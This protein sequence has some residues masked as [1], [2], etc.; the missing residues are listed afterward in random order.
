[1]SAVFDLRGQVSADVSPFSKAMDST[2]V[3]AS[4][5]FS[6]MASA[7]AMHIGNGVIRHF[8]RA[9][10]A[11]NL[12]G[13]KLAD[14][15]AIA[16]YNLKSLRTSILGIENVYGRASDVANTMYEVISSG[17]RGSEKDLMHYVQTAKHAAVSIKADLYDTASAMTN[18]TNAYGTGVAG[19]KNIADMLFVTVR[20]GKA[21]GNEL[22]RTLGLVTNTAAEAGVSLAEMS[23]AI[24][25]LSRTQSA[26]Q[27]MIGLNQL[28]NAIIKP[29]IEA[30]NEAR[31]WGIELSATALKTK[32]LSGV[33]K[34]LHEKTG[35]NVRALNAMLGNIRAMRAGVS[36]TGKQFENFMD[37]LRM[38][39]TEIGSGVAF[40]AFTKQTQTAAQAI[41]NLS[42]Q[43]D[44]TYIMI[45]SDLE[46]ITKRLANTTESWLKTIAADDFGATVGRWSMYI[47]AAA[48]GLKGIKS[49]TDMFAS[50]VK[51]L[52]D[53]LERSAGHNDALGKA[54]HTTAKGMRDV[55]VHANKALAVIQAM[56]SAMEHAAR[57]A[58]LMNSSF[59]TMKAGI[60]TPIPLTPEQ[61]EAAKRHLIAQTLKP[62][63]LK[64]EAIA[65]L[66][67][68]GVNV[69]DYT[70]DIEN[71][72]ASRDALIRK[73]D[74][75]SATSTAF[76]HSAI[77]P[78]DKSALNSRIKAMRDA[79][80]AE[81]DA[82]RAKAYKEVSVKGKYNTQFV[83]SGIGFPTPVHTPVT[84]YK[85]ASGRFVS[86]EAVTAQSAALTALS[87]RLNRLDA[88]L[89]KRG[90]LESAA[91]KRYA[92]LLKKSEDLSIAAM[93]A[94]KSIAELSD[95][96]TKYSTAQ[97]ESDALVDAESSRI[98][99]ARKLR[100]SRAELLERF[101]RQMLSDEGRAEMRAESQDVVGRAQQDRY[102]VFD[103]YNRMRMSAG[104]SPVDSEGFRRAEIKQELSRQMRS[105]EGRHQ[106]RDDSFALVR[107]VQT[108]RIDAVV[109]RYLRKHSGK[110]K[111]EE[112]ET[113]RK[114]VIKHYEKDAKRVGEMTERQ[115][116]VLA[117]FNRRYAAAGGGITARTY[118]AAMVMSETTKAFKTVGVGL[119][120]LGSFVGTTAMSISLWGGLAA[121]AAT[122]V[123]SWIEEHSAK[124]VDAIN[125]A[126]DKRDIPA[127]RQQAYKR[128]DTMYK[129][130]RIDEAEYRGYFSAINLADSRD[131]LAKIYND[132]ANKEHE[133]QPK[134][135]YED[136]T[137][138]NIDEYN[139]TLK[140][141][142]ANVKAG[143]GKADADILVALREGYTS[144]AVKLQSVNSDY[145]EINDSLV[146][147]FKEA[148]DGIG[149]G[150]YIDVRATAG[151]RGVGAIEEYVTDDFKRALLNA[152]QQENWSEA[153]KPLTDEVL[154]LGQSD[155]K[156]V[157]R[158][159]Y[160]MLN[161]I[162]KASYTRRMGDL[163]AAE[164]ATTREVQKEFFTKQLSLLTA[165]VKDAAV[166]ETVKARAAAN[167]YTVD[168]MGQSA[169]S[170]IVSNFEEILENA[171]TKNK[172]MAEHFQELLKDPKL[173]SHMT[174]ADK[175]VFQKSLD[176]RLDTAKGYANEMATYVAELVR[177][178]TTK[179]MEKYTT[180]S[181]D[182]EGNYKT[183]KDRSKML[184]DMMLEQTHHMSTATSPAAKRMYREAADALRE[185]LDTL[186]QDTGERR[187]GRTQLRKDAGLITEKQAMQDE[188]LFAQSVYKAETRRLDGMFKRTEEYA[189]QHKRVIQAGLE[190]RKS[191]LALKQANEDA[192]DSIRSGLIGQVQKFAQER[193]AQGR[194]TNDALYH[195]ISLMSRLGGGT[196]IQ[197]SKG[198]RM[199]VGNGKFATFKDAQSAQTAVSRILDAYLMSQQYAEANKGRA[200]VDIYNLLKQNIGKGI[201]VN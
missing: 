4:H 127:F 144:H 163:T 97:A 199:S 149:A 158:L 10:S 131:K 5:A 65:N 17:V 129:S 121:T 32:G 130:G 188:V 136:E 34:E 2:A 109:E 3:S 99:K 12:F 157:Q 15:S 120:K 182:A 31:N 160:H 106:M 113:V 145:Q 170:T 49:T 110:L 14:I 165:R 140:E 71:M 143:Q 53:H 153:L 117:R 89:E 92:E 51:K 70:D 197:T 90:N 64:A 40:G 185:E 61:T 114:K 102:M 86:N 195:S 101:N 35:G 138:K 54:T 178:H 119:S 105:A 122:L 172:S 146:R 191:I 39:E 76:F 19:V 186:I 24:S 198:M 179:V 60:N 147:T 151:G 132:L 29:T 156:S 43:I 159:S 100:Y 45:G 137:L 189:V 37:V 42:T 44:K 134:S 80:Q 174:E 126:S 111:P 25:I 84:R 47:G 77:E 103:R 72:R 135:T 200:V 13:Q 183:V 94:E 190:Y 33:L 73:R 162:S 125:N 21:N 79:A 104:M 168:G 78:S 74:I 20:E 59:N 6:N 62:E 173:T 48:A 87:N 55:E 175:Q 181:Y 176:S 11:A 8:V 201:V 28:L 36:L 167:I 133:L 141:R 52:S 1:M 124:Q 91:A 155:S 177:E 116:Q 58:A 150:K 180:G 82:L 30:Q 18:L 169:A 123:R 9:T 107:N 112:I 171:K 164:N 194:M 16:D 27:S 98:R 128:L 196:A 152:M 148:L 95:S 83:Q 50:S 66:K 142:I 63:N 23:A 96:I 187:R 75:A 46:P 166:D 7:A 85:D 38:A 67:K 184:R 81:Y 161:E 192:A 118:N 41:E 68:T 108:R 22:A 88:I 193:D 115:A 154:K 56:S 93:D 57:N 139:R 26:S 69:V